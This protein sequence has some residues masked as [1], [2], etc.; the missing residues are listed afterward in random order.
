MVV[1]VGCRSGSWVISFW[2]NV[3]PILN[4]LFRPF[5]HGSLRSMILYFALSLRK[6]WM[7]SL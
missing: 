3:F 2:S 4:Y 7:S 1:S 6:T 5:V